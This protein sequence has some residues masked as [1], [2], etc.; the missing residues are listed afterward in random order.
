MV[1]ITYRD[2]TVHPHACGEHNSLPCGVVVRSGSS[3]RMWGTPLFSRRHFILTRFIPTHVGN[4]FLAAGFA[5]RGSVHPHACGEHMA[6]VRLVGDRAGSS[7]RMWG[8][9][10]QTASFVKIERFIPTHVGNTLDDAVHEPFNVGSS[11]RIWGTLPNSQFCP[12][13]IRFIPTHVGNTIFAYFWFQKVAVHPHACGEHP[14]SGA[15]NS[16]LNGSSPRMWGT[17]LI[18]SDSHLSSRFI[19]THVGNTLV[20]SS[21]VGSFSV[22]PH[23]C[24]EH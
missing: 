21:S 9:Q 14:R 10:L 15:L 19:P 11:P 13:V 17:H 3:P 4:T 22:H 24:G 5:G 23:A 20:C 8:T 6:G 2:Y 16:N 18:Q 1:N 7:P 12:A